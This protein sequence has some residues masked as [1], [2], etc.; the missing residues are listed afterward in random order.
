ML[1]MA[2]AGVFVLRTDT[3]LGP[4][5]RLNA[6]LGVPFW[7]DIASR[8]IALRRCTK[9]KTTV[10]PDRIETPTQLFFGPLPHK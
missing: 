4:Q 10:L 3:Y 5:A 1:R 7:R 8:K 2:G 9:A 6:T